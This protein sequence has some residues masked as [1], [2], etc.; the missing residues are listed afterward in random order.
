[1]SDVKK[2]RKELGNESRGT[3]GKEELGQK[4]STAIFRN[5]KIQIT[6]KNGKKEQRR[7]FKKREVEITII[8]KREWSCF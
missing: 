2:L 7:I 4:R 3:T 6:M 8:E 1:M 5:E